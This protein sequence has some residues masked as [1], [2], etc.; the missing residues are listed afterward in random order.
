MVGRS[1]SGPII[2]MPISHW[3]SFLTPATSGAVVDAAQLIRIDHRSNGE[4]AL[5]ATNTGTTLTYTAAEWTAFIAGAVVGEF[6]LS[7]GALV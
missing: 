1:G 4:T 6:D 7:A 2:T 3:P 5:H